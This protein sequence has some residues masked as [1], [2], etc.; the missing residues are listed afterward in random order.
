MLQYYITFFLT[1]FL[2]GPSA[3]LPPQGVI[4]YLYGP[5]PVS[6]ST[7][8]S[9]CLPTCLSVYLP[10][11]LSTYLSL[12]LVTC[13]S[14]YLSVSLS[15]YLSL[16]LPTCLFVY[17]PVSLSTYLSLCLPTCISVYLPVYLSTY[18]S[19]ITVYYFLHDICFIFFY[20]YHLIIVVHFFCI[21]ACGL[22]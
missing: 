4:M 12:S 21:L 7:Y 15:T 14:V 11:C 13:L 8:L 16:C 18:L 6:L 17:L 22:Q 20:L 2:Q 10:V 19:G 5:L 3:P 9:L 1:L